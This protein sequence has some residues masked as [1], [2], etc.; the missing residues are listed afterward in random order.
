VAF[1]LLIDS[2]ENHKKCSIPTLSLSLCVCRGMVDLEWTYLLVYRMN[3]DDI[4]LDDSFD[5][6]FC[7]KPSLEN[8]GRGR[9]LG[10]DVHFIPIYNVPIFHCFFFSRTN[11]LVCLLSRLVVLQHASIHTHTHTHTCLR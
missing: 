10:D 7:L 6:V 1:F 8:G 9:D 3:L 11:F 5:F 4:F 2:K